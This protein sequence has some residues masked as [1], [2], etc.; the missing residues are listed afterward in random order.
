MAFDVRPLR[1]LQNRTFGSCRTNSCVGMVQDHSTLALRTRKA[2][3]PYSFGDCKF[4]VFSKR[5]LPY[6]GRSRSPKHVDVMATDAMK[7]KVELNSTVTCPECGHVS[8]E[9]MPTDACQWFYECSSC[10]TVLRPKQGDCCVYCS[11]GT[12][13]CPPIQEGT[14]C[15]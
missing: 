13:P 5:Y 7:S 12:V 9:T 14:I 2:I 1:S 3:N 11:Y 6:L 4:G 15:C 10:K 8:E